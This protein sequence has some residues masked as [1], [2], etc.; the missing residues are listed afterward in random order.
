MPKSSMSIPNLSRRAVQMACLTA[1][2]CLVWSPATA[3]QTFQSAT[4]TGSPGCSD[5]SF[6]DLIDGG[7]CSSCPSGTR[8]TVFA[9]NSAEA[10]KILAR[11]EQR[12]AT[13]HGRAG[14]FLGTDCVRGH[15][16]NPNGH[17]HSCPGGY[18]RTVFAVT[19]GKACE[20]SVSAQRS[21]ATKQG[22]AGCPRDSFFDL[23]DGGSCWSCP[24][25]YAR[26]IFSVN[27]NRACQASPQDG[28]MRRNGIRRP[29][30]MFG[31]FESRYDK[32]VDVAAQHLRSLPTGSNQ[33]FKRRSP[34]AILPTPRLTLD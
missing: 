8:R 12:D 9:V 30:D 10:R 21:R 4:R 6:F 32:I 25:G 11:P 7:T 15:F 27:G 22:S 34:T 16:W 3:E 19:S 26:A 18:N 24:P 31:W 20:R 5:G 2:L 14:G 23:I 28:F 29:E 13:D 1:L 17:C 33:E